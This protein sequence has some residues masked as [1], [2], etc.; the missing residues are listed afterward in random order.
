MSKKYLNDIDLNGKLTIA[1][2]GGTNG[3]FLKTDGSGN[4]SWAAGGGGSFTGGTLTSNLTLFAGTNTSAPLKFVSGTNLITAAAGNMEYDGTNLYFTPS[5][6]RKT[7]AF[8]DSAMTGTVNGITFTGTSSTTMTFPSTTA[9]IARTDTGQTFS[10]SQIF[11]GSITGSSSA[12]FANPALTGLITLGTS[13]T[14]THQVEEM[15]TIVAT[16]YAGYSWN[17]GGT[18][19]IIY[20]TANS[21][22]T[23][24]LALSWTGPGINTAFSVGTSWTGTILL[25]NGATPFYI[26]AMT[27]D[28]AAQTIKW[29][30]GVAPS[31]GS[32]NSIDAYTFVVIKTASATYTV[33]GT[34]AKFA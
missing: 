4:I 30:Q 26:N 25:T 34:F 20:I 31:A 8:T 21:T 29:T 13:G 22:A 6:T 16:G 19:N 3:Y 11:T 14:P 27:I 24:T 12:T 33:L 10:G 28:G 5:T 7:I 32:A 9:T 23:G 1:T 15:V 18:S 17:I 2:S